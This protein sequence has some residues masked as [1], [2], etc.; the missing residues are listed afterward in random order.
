VHCTTCFDRHWSS[1]GV[2]NCRWK[3]LCFRF[4]TLIFD[5]WSHLRAHVFRGAGCLFLLCCMSR[6]R[7]LI[8]LSHL[9]LGF[10]SGFFPSSFPIKTRCNP[11]PRFLHPLAISFS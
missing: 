6:L 1:S 4:V 11:L 10:P 7:M 9:R 2:Q 8:L 3:L 5:V